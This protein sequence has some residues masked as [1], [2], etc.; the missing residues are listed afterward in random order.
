[1]NDD[2]LHHVRKMCRH[3]EA[4]RD[5]LREDVGKVDDPLFRQMFGEASIV[6]ERLIAAFR[7]YEQ[8]Q[9]QGLARRSLQ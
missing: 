8:R 2:P 9:D 3:L 1:M 5:H 6:L 4:T 7:V